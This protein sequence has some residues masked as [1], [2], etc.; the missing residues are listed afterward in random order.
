MPRVITDLLS[1]ISM[2]SA[3]A[4]DPF[5]A[6]P[7]ERYPA[8]RHRSRRLVPGTLLAI[9]RGFTA[10]VLRPVRA[11]SLRGPTPHQRFATGLLARARPGASR[12]QRGPQGTPLGLGITSR[13]SGPRHSLVQVW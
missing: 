6:L 12:R 3:S 5:T 8:P 7:S 10:A 2:G 4:T 13:C 1:E 11:L 9:G